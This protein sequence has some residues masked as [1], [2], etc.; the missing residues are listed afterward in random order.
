MSWKLRYAGKKV[1]KRPTECPVIT[2]KSVLKEFWRNYITRT[3]LVKLK[4]YT[5]RNGRTENALW[6]STITKNFR[7][8]VIYFWI[9]NLRTKTLLGRTK[10]LLRE[11][12]LFLIFLFKTNHTDAKIRMLS[13]LHFSQCNYLLRITQAMD[14]VY[15]HVGTC[16]PHF[17]ISER[18]DLWVQNWWV[19]EDSLASSFPQMEVGRHLHVHSCSPLFLVS[20]TAELYPRIHTISTHISSTLARL[21]PNMASYW[22]DRLP[23]LSLPCPFRVLFLVVQRTRKLP[24]KENRYFRK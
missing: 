18:S 24:P 3:Y 1:F 7:T 23:F 2:T 14:A 10:V 19:V 13:L 21:L 12:L 16:T 5:E 9:G 4:C 22:L 20:E 11:R 8:C 6:D 15:L 17:C